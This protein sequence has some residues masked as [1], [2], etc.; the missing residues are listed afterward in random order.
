[1]RLSTAVLLAVITGAA[2]AG[3]AEWSLLTAFHSKNG[4]TPVGV[5]KLAFDHVAQV[6]TQARAYL[7]VVLQ[8]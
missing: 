1:M 2:I 4:G 6:K 3:P 5:T 8:M 7:E